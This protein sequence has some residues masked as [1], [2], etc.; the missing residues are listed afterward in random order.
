MIKVIWF[1]K[2]AEH[3]EL[4]AFQQWWAGTHASE[5]ARAQRPYLKRYVVNLRRP[6]DPLTGRPSHDLDWDGCAE[7]WFDSEADFDAAQVMPG[8]A[9][10]NDDFVQHI[11]RVARMVVREA[12]IAI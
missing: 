8:M 4:E 10:I 5:I 3:L 11:S 1:L 2:R 7:Q 9:A 12:P 6:V